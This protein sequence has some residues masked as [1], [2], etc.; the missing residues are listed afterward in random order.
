[1][2]DLA[3][4]PGL[5]GGAP[6]GVRAGRLVPRAP[7]HRPGHLPPRRRRRS[8]PAPRSPWC[9]TTRRR[10]GGSR[11][12]TTATTTREIELTSYGEIVL[13]PPDADRA[14][15]AFGNLFVETEWHDWCTAITATRRPRSANERPLWC[16]H[17]VD[18]GQ[19]RV[20]PVTLRD[21]PRPVRRPRA[22]PRAIPRRWTPAA[23]LSRHHRRRAR[24]DLRAP[25]AG[26]A[27]AAASRRRSRS[28]RSSPRPRE[29]AFELADRYHDPHAAQRALDL[30]W[31]STPGGAARARA[32]RRRDAAVFQELAG[33][34]FYANP[35]LRAPAGR[36]A[37]EPRLAAAALG[38]RRLGR[39][40][41]PARDDRLGG[42]PADAAPAA[43]GAPLLAAPRHD[44]GPRRAQRAPAELPA[45][46]A[47]T[48]SSPRCIASQRRRA[49]VDQPGGVFVR[50]ARPARAGRAA[51]AARHGARA[52]R[53]RRPLA[54]AGSWRRPRAEDD[55]VAEDLDVAA[56]RRRR[57]PSA[58]RAG[59]SRVLSVRRDRRPPPRRR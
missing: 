45:G 38:H 14:H 53:L 4:R 1:M 29:R 50:R 22:H 18:A 9:R 2:K 49:C 19:E 33:H 25:R 42:G 36:A 24:S 32:S 8:R 6:A 28:P 12:P 43:R 16:V 52:H 31:T 37:A 10:C 34:L 3:D 20:G 23:P 35:A 59:C 21:R 27:R 48:G 39:L 57:A 17:V 46:A 54:R 26:A 55:A 7:R 15:P 58:A 47:T 56:A 44:G 30:A 51:H 41:D 40:A 13:A 11:S 5:V